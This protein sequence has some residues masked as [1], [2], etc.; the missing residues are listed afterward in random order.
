MLSVGRPEIT[1]VGCLPP[2]VFRRMAILSIVGMRD[3]D[4]LPLSRTILA[5]L[6]HPQLLLPVATNLC[7]GKDGERKTNGQRQENLNES[8]LL[9]LL[10]LFV[11][12]HVTDFHPPASVL[13]DGHGNAVKILLY[14]RLFDECV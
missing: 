7:T 2:I 6:P 11:N 1:L 14:A 3:R 10:F 9:F 5:E 4:S 8:H 13:Y 12:L